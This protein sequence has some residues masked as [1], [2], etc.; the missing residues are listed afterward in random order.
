[1]RLPPSHVVTPVDSHHTPRT[2]QFFNGRHHLHL[3]KPPPS[4]PSLLPI[5]DPNKAGGPISHRTNEANPQRL[6]EL[7]RGVGNPG[8]AEKGGGEPTA[9]SQ[10]GPGPPATATHPRRRPA[11]LPPGHPAPTLGP[12]AWA[13]KRQSQEMLW[14]VWVYGQKRLGDR[15]GARGPGG[16]C[17]GR[18][19]RGRGSA[20][21]GSVGADKGQTPL[22]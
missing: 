14:E 22:A 4:H 12:P 5:P 3:G 18:G 19:I 17:E 20:A 8:P 2:P 9:Q 1:M 15:A 13:I 7:G 6:G 21:T 10:P 16:G 11:A